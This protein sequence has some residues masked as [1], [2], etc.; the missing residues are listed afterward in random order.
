M[1]CIL[2]VELLRKKATMIAKVIKLIKYSFVALFSF[3]FFNSYLHIGHWIQMGK[4]WKLH[5]IN[6][7]I[8]IL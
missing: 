8:S 4:H 7:L 5:Y 3:K 6:R 2:T 1:E